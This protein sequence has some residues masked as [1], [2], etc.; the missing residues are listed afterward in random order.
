MV[1]LIRRARAGVKV[2]VIVDALYSGEQVLGRTNPQLEALSPEDNIEVVVGSPIAFGRTLDSVALK[3]RDHRKLLVVDGQTGFVTG[4]NISDAYYRGFDETPIHQHTA[5]QHIPWLDAHVEATGPIVDAIAAMFAA[6]W[7]EYGGRHRADLNPSESPRTGTCTARLVV[8]NGLVDANGMLQYEAMLDGARDH[9]YIVNDFP[10]VASLA[11]AMQRAL[12]RGVRL[13]LLTGNAVAR[14]ADGSFF[15]GPV[16]RELFDHMVKQRLEPLI[17]S[18]AEVYEYAASPDPMIVPRGGVVRPYVHAKVMSCDGRAASV[19]SANLDATASYWEHEANMV[20]QDK[21]F[22]QGLERQV[23][24]MIAR[25]H[26][27]DLD[28]DYWKR[29]RAKRAIVAKLWP[30]I[31]YS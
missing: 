20:V 26:A 25:A 3:Q 4:R 19:G 31:V 13:V 29:D 24:E 30:S 27:I 5:H 14:R 17:R 15:P 22:T 2:R 12:S 9:V 28:S 11:S 21:A 18:G 10:I 6:A 1:R 8:H 7:T 23:E 16:Y